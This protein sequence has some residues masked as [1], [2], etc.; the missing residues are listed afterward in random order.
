MRIALLS[1]GPAQ[2][3]LLR[4][5]CLAAGHEVPVHA[6]SRS[7]RP[8]SPT[9][10]GADDAAAI[11]AALPAGTDLV[12]P[13]TSQGL[14][15]ALLGYR[16]DLVVCYGFSWRLPR[17]VLDIPRYGVLN[18]HSSLLP[19]YRGPAPVHWAIRN[20]DPYLG[21]TV[22][23]MDE[24]FDA[25]PVLGQRGGVPIPEDV[26][27]E[28][29]WAG[30]APVLSELLTAALERAPDPTAG[31]PQRQEGASYAGLM[32]PEFFAVDPAR[33]AREVHD[34]VRTFRFM[35]PGLGPAAIVA[36]R[37]LTVLR[38]SRIPADGLRLDCADGPL[39]ITEWQDAPA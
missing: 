28:G 20:G 35:G 27:P 12:L 24:E 13:G 29:L 16:L 33:T 8:H 15:T 10:P 22:H 3:Q 23:R 38:T 14:G 4:D 31:E 26:T 6:F 25:G 1:F 5:T 30:I 2:F 17:S 18:V 7:L 37:R 19:A 34:Q 21:L 9:D 36:G 11:V 39:W 32:E